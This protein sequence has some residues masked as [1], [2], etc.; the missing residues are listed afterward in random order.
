MDYQRLKLQ[1]VDNSLADAGR[2]PRTVEVEVTMVKDALPLASQL[3][4]LF[5]FLF[6][7]FGVTNTPVFQRAQGLVDSCSPGD[8]VTIVGV[9]K[10]VNADHAAGRGGKRAA[11]NSLFILYV[12]A[13]SVTNQR[14]A[15]AS[16]PASSSPTPGS[17]DRS[18]SSP[19]FTHEDL[20]AIREVAMEPGAFARVVSSICPSIFGH[21]HVKAGLALGL[22]GGA[23]SETSSRDRLSVRS[24]PHILV[25][26]DPGLGKSQMLRAACALAPRSVY[27]SANTTTATG[28][29]VTV[30]KESGSGGDVVLEAGALVLADQGVCCV[31]EFDKI[32]C[33]S[34][35]LLE[36]MEQQSV[37]IAKSGIVA[38]LSA[39]CSVLAA[40][41]P[42]GGHYDSSKTINE[43][44]KMSAALLSRFDLVFILL[45][46]PEEAHDRKLSEYIMRSHAIG[47]PRPSSSMVFATAS[48]CDASQSQG[49]VLEATNRV[50]EQIKRGA[51]APPIPTE[52]LR[53]YVLY[54]RKYVHPKLTGAAATVLQG[55]CYLSACVSFLPPGVL[56]FPLC[57]PLFVGLYLKIRDRARG[58]D[59]L[60]IT[61]R[62]LESLVKK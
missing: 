28:L 59:S 27:V 7:S 26:G 51:H 60:P 57:V 39:R 49:P 21:D 10:S 2:V 5:L 43:N 58:G 32:G 25:V 33:D 42:H 52:L 22:F 24:D 6:P 1:E 61:T 38:N 62:Q 41:N 19:G 14:S 11:A 55:K 48:G 53:K 9:V 18:S 8:L 23:K 56:V 35:C 50:V 3:S 31:D 13:N 15:S 29:T 4:T 47:E 34:H 12:A 40:A 54:A 20:R 46:K 44:L 17:E 45:D 37:S 36:A 30:S 16:S